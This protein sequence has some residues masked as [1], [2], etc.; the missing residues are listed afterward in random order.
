MIRE[1]GKATKTMCSKATPWCKKNPF[2][3]RIMVLAVEGER[4]F[5]MPIRAYLIAYF[6]SIN[7]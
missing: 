7:P 1:V 6:K 4:L 5:D 3:N 2:Q